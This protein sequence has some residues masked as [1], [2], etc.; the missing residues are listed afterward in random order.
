MVTD[1]QGLK[2]TSQERGR[3][4]T[5]PPLSSCCYPSDKSCLIFQVVYLYHFCS[6]VAKIEK[7]ILKWI[8]NL[9]VFISLMF[10][11]TDHS[12]AVFIVNTM[13]L[14]IF[15]TLIEPLIYVTLP[16]LLQTFFCFYFPFQSL[17]RWARHLL[18]SAFL[19]AS[20]KCCNLALSCH[21]TLIVLPLTTG[22]SAPLASS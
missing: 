12:V 18:Y 6:N 13:K 20:T 7:V 3:L 22:R 8:Q 11:E 9:F 16:N 17:L 19:N 4:L 15:E 21:T 10:I 2:K 14:F 5:S 1:K